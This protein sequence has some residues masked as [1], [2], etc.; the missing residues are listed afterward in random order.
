MGLIKGDTRTLEYS[1]YGT[2]LFMLGDAHV[3]TG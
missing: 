1:S 2:F 3:M